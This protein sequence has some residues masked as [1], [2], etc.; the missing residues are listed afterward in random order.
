MERIAKFALHAARHAPTKEARERLDRAYMSWATTAERELVRLTCSE[1]SDFGLTKSLRGSHARL[2]LRSVITKE[3]TIWQSEGAKPARA[4]KWVA[5]RIEEVLGLDQEGVAFQ[6]LVSALRFNPPKFVL[7]SEEGM[8]IRR[9]FGI[10]GISDE[11]LDLQTPIPEL[12]AQEMEEELASVQDRLGELILKAQ[13]AGRKDWVE[14]AS[15]ALDQGAAKAHRFAREPEPW[16]PTTVLVEGG[17]VAADPLLLLEDLGLKWGEIWQAEH[18]QGAIQCVE[19][20][21]I[22]SLCGRGD[23]LDRE[24]TTRLRAV[25]AAYKASSAT[26]V[27]GFHM[28]H[29]SMLSDEG[30]GVLAVLY[31]CM[32]SHGYPPSQDSTTARE[33]TG[34]VQAHRG[35]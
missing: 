6:K 9:A 1:E 31:Q 7:E 4:V 17:R 2:K 14:W 15:G 21:V 26:S 27:D 13:A 29:F 16:N 34:G 28:K 22:T 30:L 19:D 3:G 20:P 23:P 18:V 35:L 24:S 25:S 5:G 8:S 10:M 32:E 11:E 33:A 12:R